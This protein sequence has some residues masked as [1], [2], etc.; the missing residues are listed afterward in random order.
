MAGQTY[1][2]VVL[3]VMSYPGENYV[4]NYNSDPEKL[5]IFI[6]LL[7]SIKVNKLKRE[8]KG[9]KIKKSISLK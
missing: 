6:T 2:Q 4:I 5:L 8:N 3:P 7:F 9:L 1:S